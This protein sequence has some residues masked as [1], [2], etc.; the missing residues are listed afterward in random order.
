MMK[1][2]EV[3]R[4]NGF[5]RSHTQLGAWSRADPGPLSRGR[6][7]AQLAILSGKGFPTFPQYERYE[8]P[9]DSGIDTSFL[10]V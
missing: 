6:T 8:T 1:M 10:K 5:L 9:N 2:R 7:L 4:Y 3:Q